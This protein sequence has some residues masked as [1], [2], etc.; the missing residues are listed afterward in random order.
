M[1]DRIM[2]D[3]HLLSATA[4]AEKIRK[5]EI[6]VTEVA[7]A[8]LA[9]IDEVNPKLN[10]IVYLDREQVLAD[11]MEQDAYIAGG[12][13][14]GPIQGVPFT[15]K[16]NTAVAGLPLTNGFGPLKDNVAKEDA[17][18]TKRFREAGGL[19]IGK[20]N[21]PE[22]GYYGG[23]ENGLYGAAHNPFKHGYSTGGSSGGGAASIAAG[24]TALTE[25]ND[26]AGSVRIPGSLCGVLGLKPT[27]GLVPE[28]LMPGRYHSF[29]FHGPLTR[30]VD[31][32]A[33]QM[34]LWAGPSLADPKSIE[35]PVASFVEASKGSVRGLR[36]AWS[37]DLGLGV[38]VDPEV[39][40]VCRSVLNELPQLGVAVI[41]A[42]PTWGVDVS[43][44]MW[45][46][47]WVPGY[48]E[49]HDDFDWDALRGQIDDNLI[50]IMKEAEALTAVGVGRATKARGNMFDAWT[51][52]ME[53][54][55]ILA[56]P[57][58]ASATFPHGKFAP[59]WLDGKSVR[60]R[61][62]DWLLTYP[63]NMLTNPAITVPAGFTADGRPVGIQF[64]ARNREDAALLRLA[65]NIEEIRPWADSY[66]QI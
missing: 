8:T 58:L 14:L 17:P 56:S 19:F 45:D 33:L 62:L 30:N 66:A 10:A 22:F 7:E 42:T 3:I 39:I 53:D 41:E 59:E 21:L 11:A 20:T 24:I 4:L 36:V 38:H 47:S 13:E 46:G 31:D 5:R 43:E 29:I 27:V 49:I 28:T 18:V 23:C 15:I 44:A 40:A 9:R 65:R 32:C 54:Y 48:A 26:G 34:D 51:T 12:G 6:S 2:T 61:I 57:T 60:E 16:D 50:E 25:G 55:D 63:Y 35:K 52:F 64:A 37:D 1:T